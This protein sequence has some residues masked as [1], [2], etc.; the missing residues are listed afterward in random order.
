MNKRSLKNKFWTMAFTGLL[1]WGGVVRVYAASEGS[2]L[3]SLEKDGEII[4]Y[5]E[6]DSTVTSVDAQVAQ[7]PCENVEVT[8]LENI[9]VHTVILLD[10]SLSVTQENRG[11]I[12][13]I[14]RQYVQEMPEN[15]R[16]SLAAFGE[17]IQFLAEKSGDRNE[18]AGLIDTIE[19]Q[20]QDTYLTDFLYQALER[21]ET[22]LEYTRFVVISDGVDNKA[23]GITK[24]ELTDKL[25]DTSRPIYTI[26]HKYGENSDQ[27]KN[28]FA[29]SRITNGKEFLIEDFEDIGRIAEEIH[30]FSKI[31]SLR[32]DIP[33]D[34]M[35]GGSKHI[36]L[37][38]HTQDGDLELTGEVCM[39]FGLVE[40]EPEPTPEPT[41]QPTPEPTPQPAL[42]ASPEPVPTP[43]QAEK[44][45]GVDPVKIAGLVVLVFGAAGFLI[46]HK[47][48]KDSNKVR[49]SK[50]E[51]V[52]A[53]SKSVKTVIPEPMSVEEPSGDET[54][55]LDGRYLLVL[56]DR[57][58]PERI[59]RYPMDQ[60]VVV[61]R[62]TDKV[63]I[64][65]DYNRTIS[66]QHCEFYVRGG[67]FFIRDMGSA[68]HTYL[69]GHMLNGEAEVTSGSIV[70]M[71]EVE[72]GV[73]I[74]PI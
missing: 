48:N 30:D 2:L 32:M 23:I 68:N 54:V 12:K 13:E 47:R 74:M 63:Q 29:L 58:N 5:I 7:Y 3:Q 34:V 4:A 18:L 42:Q 33:R 22:D 38:V 44:T 51:K 70:R 21:I 14:L 17:D 8:T 26:G 31:S 1:L 52:E 73:E 27:L 59:F 72:F 25:K 28:M 66:G 6:S 61:G 16:V 20:D 37:N 36:L 15:E 67:C 50:K 53:A 64:A 9:S 69:G 65:V 10:N 57:A 11:D 62:N 41:P 19:F 60:H 56:R 45:S 55:V 46:C 35:D 49:E 40:N 71:G 43:A 39:P 24:E